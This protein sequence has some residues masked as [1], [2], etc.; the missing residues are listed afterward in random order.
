MDEYSNAQTKPDKSNI[1]SAVVEHV[2]QSGNFVKKDLSSGTWYYAEDLLCREKC[3]QTFRD[4][5]HQ[6][7]RSSNVAKKNKRLRELQQ[8][9]LQQQRPSEM[10]A[11]HQAK[12]MRQS[13]PTPVAPTPIAA[14]LFDWELAPMPHLGPPV[15]RRTS[16]LSGPMMSV[17][18]DTFGCTDVLDED[19]N[20]FEPTP[21]LP[22]PQTNTHQ[23]P[24]T[25]SVECK[26]EQRVVTFEPKALLDRDSFQ[27]RRNSIFMGD[28]ISAMSR[29]VY[30]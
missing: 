1:I 11:V 22:P 7:Y 2:R 28:D 29:D 4:A 26:G 23:A 25:M 12:R 16:A 9:Q 21:L 13:D 10:E 18:V 17:L 27:F 6:T 14:H 15:S 8:E 3:S 30:G 5:L 19:E 20:P 24:T